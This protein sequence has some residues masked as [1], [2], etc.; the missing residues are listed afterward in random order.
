MCAVVLSGIGPWHDEM[1][2]IAR[3]RRKGRY[4]PFRSNE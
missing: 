1:D 3:T 2:V 4:L